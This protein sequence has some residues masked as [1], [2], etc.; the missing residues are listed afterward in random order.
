MIK[1]STITALFLLTLALTGCG[2]SNNNSAQGYIEGRFTYV[3]S[4]NTG[5][6]DTIDVTR[7]DQVKSG[8][9]LFKLDP[10]PQLAGVSQAKAQLAQAQA[11]LANLE[12]GKRPSEL[13]AIK[14]QQRQATAQMIYAKK[15][16][17]RYRTLLKRGVIEKARVDQ[18]QSQYDDFKAQR[19]QLTE[20]LKT[21]KLSARSDQIQAAKEDVKAQAAVLKQAQWQ[22]QQK[23]I[24]APITGQ[25]Y[26]TYYRIGETVPAGHAVLSILAP[27]NVYA[28]FF[29]SEEKLATIHTGQSI[30]IT[31]DSCTKPTNA[32][33]YFISPQAEYTPPIIYSETS[34]SKLVYRVE[35]KLNQADA[36]KLHPGQPIT[37][38]F[39]KKG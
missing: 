2:N 6:L 21:A 18:Q 30:S 34:R 26:D 23:T 15:M 38:T 20:N 3:S 10:D 28:V 36:I 13:A 11:S 24:T 31:C 16:L 32:S 12:K 25:V 7:G 22:L 8:Q 27:T 5:T 19:A 37:V 35:A 9:A 33:V 4:Q 29:I 1:K 14:A 39:T 17:V